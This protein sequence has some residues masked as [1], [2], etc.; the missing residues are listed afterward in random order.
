MEHVI[1]Q[2]NGLDNSLKVES[3][4]PLSTKLGPVINLK[5]LESPKDRY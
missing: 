1:N 2:T 5:V 4:T 3:N